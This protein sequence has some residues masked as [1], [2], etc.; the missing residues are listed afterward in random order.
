MSMK[1]HFQIPVIR[2]SKRSYRRDGRNATLMA[3]I[4]GC[5]F[6]VGCTTSRPD[7]SSGTAYSWATSLSETT[8]T[9]PELN[10]VP[11]TAMAASSDSAYMNEAWPW[12]TPRNLT[13]PISTAPIQARKPGGA[14]SM[15]EARGQGTGSRGSGPVIVN[16]NQAPATSAEA[17]AAATNS[18]ATQTSRL[19][20]LYRGQFDKQASRELV[21]FGYDFF[22]NNPTGPDTV[23]PVPANYVLGPGDEVSI[24]LSGAVEAYHSLVIDRDGLLS[25]PDFGP[26]HL[27]GETFGNLEQVILSFLEE[28][29]HGF[30]L[31]VSLGRLRRIQVNMVGRVNNP[32]VVEISAL[33][34]PITAL[35][36]AGGPSK[37]GSLRKIV[38]RRAGDSETK[39]V[40]VDLY[41]TL[42]GQADTSAVP[43]L[44]DG[45]TLIVPAVGTTVGIAGYVQQPGIYEVKTA[46]VSVEEAIK[47]AG[48]LTPFSFTPL[49]HLERTVDG[50]GRQRVDVEL[51]PEGMAQSM[52][53]GELLLVEAVD[54]D[55]QPVVR[56]EGEVARP[57]DFE[58]RTGMTLSELV[59]R[60]DGLTID[61]YL[62]QAFISRQV[63]PSSSIEVIP[64]RTA[65]L[66]SRRVIVVDLGKA[67]AGDPEHDAILM[68]LDLITIRSQFRAQVRST[69]EIIG[70]VQSPGTY[71]M[72]AGMRVSDL[73]AI[74]GN[75]TS[76][77]YYDEAELIRRV[78]D[79]ETRRLDVR[80]FRIDLRQALHPA[81]TNR[82]D[83]NPLLN[84]G[85]RL[86]IRALQQAQVRVKID[87]R[88]RFPGEYIFP[89]GAQL[90]DLI[91]AAGGILPDAD[92]RAAHF[93]RLSTKALQQQRLNHLIERTR[94][95][96]EEA[97]ERMVQTGR[98]NEGLAGRISLEQGQ[99]TLGRI[100]NVEADGRI[101]IPFSTPDFPESRYNLPL[102][103]GDRLLIPRYHSTISV[104]GHVFRPITLVAGETITVSDALEQ[105][106]GLTELADEDLL[107]VVR[108]DGSVDSVA[109]SPARLSRKTELLAGDVLLVPAKPIERTFGAQLADAL[110]LARQI[111]EVALVGSQY[112]KDLD[113]T[114]VS[115]FQQETKASDPAILRD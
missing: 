102:E 115:P 11:G 66:Q 3:T 41:D 79:E 90:T 112:G 58:H 114:L 31:T 103:N 69:V 37:D 35:L 15:G 94:R 62:P 100:Q 50:R 40:E 44:Q 19:E 56:I 46:L 38:L 105:A 8:E 63:G 59:K 64:D 6:L 86:V 34:T 13:Q 72:T 109:Q 97:F 57:G 16:V 1:T 91:S 45:D 104:A 96:S 22:E 80:R 21:Q 71:E 53:N 36:A 73:V 54:D 30:D 5:L 24:S 25:I 74:A 39:A 9:V 95:L 17:E 7:N 14:Q 106:G 51:T 101:V 42:Q 32:G 61:A 111:A 68:P 27:A 110:M 28:R 77:V 33:G 107:Y 12:G 4:L 48:G 98:S 85:D 113:M 99:E 82:P 78:L 84:N 47:L 23:G 108:A 75:P 81:N 92:L 83:M 76:D 87:G 65:H 20:K 55:R 29:R 52:G 10:T 26:I 93:S 89:A 88:V 70:S 2:S 49:A 18:P 60:A 43:V 67:L